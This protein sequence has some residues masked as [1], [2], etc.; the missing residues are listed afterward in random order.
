MKPFTTITTCTLALVGLGMAWHAGGELHRGGHLENKPNPLGLKMSPYGQVIAMAIQAPIDDDWHGA[1]EIH[2]MPGAETECPETQ[3]ASEDHGHD[4]GTCEHS[5]CSGCDHDDHSTCSHDEAVASH[6]GHQC[7]DPSCSHDPGEATPGKDEGIVD[8]LSRAVKK[9]TNPNPPTVG[10]QLY[11]RREIEKKFR[12]AYELDPSHYAN[13]AVY[14][15]FLLHNELGTSNE[16]YDASTVFATDLAERT[17]RYCLRE[18]TDPRPALTAAAAAYNILEIMFT[19]PDGH[20]T[21]EMRE[22]LAVLDFCLKRHFD[23][24]E[25]ADRSGVWAKISEARQNEI[26]GRSRLTIKLR[27]AAEKTIIRFEGERNNTASN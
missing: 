24:L 20:T 18:T 23:L 1:L 4:H 15:L 26:F 16:G 13:Y 14:H 17:I 10:H 25:E 7:S 12:F 9:R 2:D 19:R 5:A 27:E 11:I 3:I 21:S 6:H 8:R 22:Q